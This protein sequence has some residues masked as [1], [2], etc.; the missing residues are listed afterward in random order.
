MAD[1]KLSQDMAGA[2]GLMRQK[3]KVLMILQSILTAILL[4]FIII[5]VGMGMNKGWILKTELGIVIVLFVLNAYPERKKAI[6][7]YVLLT[8]AAV[9]CFTLQFI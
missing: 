7:F 1:R 4:I 6:V 5:D 2:W 8:L 9:V 3:E